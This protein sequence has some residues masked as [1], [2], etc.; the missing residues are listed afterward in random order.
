[1]EH[2][3]AEHLS[4]RVKDVSPIEGYEKVYIVKIWDSK[5]PGSLFEFEI[6]YST[7]N[8]YNVAVVERTKFHRRFEKGL[9]DILVEMLNLIH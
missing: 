5:T 3:D 2:M 1:M 7:P 9:L 8:G 4:Y 6:L